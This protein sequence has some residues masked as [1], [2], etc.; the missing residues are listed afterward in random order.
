VSSDIEEFEL[1]TGGISQGVSNHYDLA[2]SPTPS[3]VKVLKIL[4]RGELDYELNDN[5]FNI[6]VLVLVLAIIV[7]VIILYI[8]WKSMK[9]G[10]AEDKRFAQAG[11]MS[12]LSE[13]PAY[14]MNEV[15][16]G[17]TVSTNNAPN[18]YQ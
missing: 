4:Q 11:K 2:I 15:R 6:G 18:G 13:G 5:G 14:D 7:F 1:Y 16:Q 8:L 3:P 9:N 17:S 12:E 10:E